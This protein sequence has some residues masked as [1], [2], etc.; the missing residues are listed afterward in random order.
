MN[1]RAI[2]PL[3]AVMLLIAACGPTA[4]PAN[5]DTLI[6]GATQAGY[7]PIDLSLH[8]EAGRR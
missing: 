4:E 5:G 2:G 3:L 7:T 6:S 8:D 1:T